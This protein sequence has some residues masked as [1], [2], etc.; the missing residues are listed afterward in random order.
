MKPKGLR[1]LYILHTEVFLNSGIEIIFS[2]KVY[3]DKESNSVALNED[4]D[5]CPYISF[6]KLL[7]ITFQDWKQRE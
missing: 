5:I 1:T 7:G 2:K 6:L 3:S 4:L